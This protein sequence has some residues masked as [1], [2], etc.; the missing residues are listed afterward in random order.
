VE[1]ERESGKEIKEREKEEEGKEMR[2]KTLQI[3]IKML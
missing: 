3:V 2:F 1:E